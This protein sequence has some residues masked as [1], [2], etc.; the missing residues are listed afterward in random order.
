M[1]GRTGGDFE[2]GPD[3]Q[4]IAQ[5]N[6]RIQSRTEDVITI[7][8]HNNG[9]SC[10]QTYIFPSSGLLL[11]VNVK[12][13]S[14]TLNRKLYD[15]QDPVY[16]NARGNTQALPDGHVVVGQ[17]VAPKFEEYDED[18]NLVMRAWFGLD[19]EEASYAA[20]RSNWTGTPQTAPDISVKSFDDMTTLFISWNG[21][22]GVDSWE[23]SLGPNENELEYVTTARKSGFETKVKI[24]GVAAFVRVKAIGGPNDGR[25]SEIISVTAATNVM[26]DK[27]NAELR[28]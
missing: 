13:R 4:F 11:D 10:N 21:A 19:D 16:A 6:A 27:I 25:Q 28:K 12:T 18:D 3:T 20:I 5:H 17:G 14:V 7:S 23:I 22:T 8:L 1:Q 9:A 26:G 2:L 15:S 24:K